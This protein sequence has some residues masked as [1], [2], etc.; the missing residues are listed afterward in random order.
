MLRNCVKTKQQQIEE[1]LPIFMSNFLPFLDGHFQESPTL[2]SSF[3]N[4]YTHTNESKI[5][6]CKEGMHFTA[7]L[8]GFLCS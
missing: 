7:K 6:I 4:I 8:K 5:L 2:F 3:K 1:F